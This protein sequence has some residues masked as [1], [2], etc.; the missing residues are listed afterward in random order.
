LRWCRQNALNVRQETK[1][2]QI[3]VF[4]YRC[5]VVCGIL[6]ASSKSSIRNI[7]CLWIALRFAGNAQEIKTITKS[8]SAGG[9][10]AGHTGSVN[11][12]Q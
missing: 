8:G 6:L 5:F 1:A 10:R 2:R 4:S 3:Y 9:E 12:R 7:Q 11:D